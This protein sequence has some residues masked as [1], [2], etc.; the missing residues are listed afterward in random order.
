MQP[1]H[2]TQFQRHLLSGD[3]SSA[4]DLLPQLAPDAPSLAACRFLVLQQKYLEALE[5]REFTVALGCLRG[6]LAPLGINEHQLHHLAGAGGLWVGAAFGGA[7]GDCWGS[8]SRC[9]SD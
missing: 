2:A 1:P 7:Q 8:A 9:N 6:E 4:L 5:A 3:W